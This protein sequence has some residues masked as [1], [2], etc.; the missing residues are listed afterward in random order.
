MFFHLN[1][2]DLIGY[3]IYRILPLLFEVRDRRSP[4]AHHKREEEGARAP[5]NTLILCWGST[6]APWLLR[7]LIDLSSCFFEPLPHPLT[8]G[9]LCARGRGV[10]T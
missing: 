8:N 2:Y 9:Q 3:T 6:L 5:S 1:G 7:G 4:A 10:V